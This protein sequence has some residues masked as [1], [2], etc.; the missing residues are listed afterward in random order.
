[1]SP[2]VVAEPILIISQLR[3][4]SK[5]PR[6]SASSLLSAPPVSRRDCGGLKMYVLQPSALTIQYYSYAFKITCMFQHQL[7]FVDEKT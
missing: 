5:L 4:G 3:H 6:L 7:V 1:M 2:K